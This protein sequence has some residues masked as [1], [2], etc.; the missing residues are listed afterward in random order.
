MHFARYI[1]LGD[2]ISIGLYPALDV[3]GARDW[4]V[5]GA[6]RREL[7]AA[8]LLYRN[9]DAM[10]P[11]FAGRDLASLH[12]GIAFRDEHD[13]GSPTDGEIDNLATDGATTE[14]VRAHQIPR[15]E[16]SEE[17]TL[18][19]LSVGG[20]DLLAALHRNP[21]PRNLVAGIASRLRRMLRDVKARRPNSSI[22]AT[23]VYDPS[24]GTNDLG[25]GRPLDEAAGWLA[26]YNLQL[27]VA[28]AEVEGACVADIR[29]HFFGHGVTAASADRWYWR[30]SII[31]PSA[32]GA[33]EVRRVW[34]RC[35]A[36]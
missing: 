14:D 15:I 8:S 34:L 11:E 17:P 1:A 29:A 7:G 26:D 32:R 13:L 27:R 10:W 36:G 24:D 6:L 16:P 25:D 3:A 21:A 4:V 28:T 12:P 19:T 2:S 33:S 35:L 20:N 9:D 23:N 22:L 31:E 18:L 5:P 30:H